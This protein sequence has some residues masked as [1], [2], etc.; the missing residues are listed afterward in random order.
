MVKQDSVL[1]YVQLNSVETS[2]PK[3]G[4]IPEEIQ[5]LIERY[6]SIFQPL[7]G[8]PPK[9]DGDHTMPLMPGASPFRLR[10]Y[11]YNPFQK[12]KIEKQIQEVLDKGLIKHSSSPFSSLALLVRKE[13]RRLAFMCGL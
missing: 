13:N 7:P 4:T 11:R 10:P 9:R 2:K 3:E 6:S 12:D 1:Y 5:T 8:L